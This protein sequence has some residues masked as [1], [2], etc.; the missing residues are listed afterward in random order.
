MMKLLPSTNMVCYSKHIHNISFP[1]FSVPYLLMPKS[2]TF[3]LPPFLPSS[4]PPSLISS[5]HHICKTHKQL[6]FIAFQ[7]FFL[8][9]II[10][11][12][13]SIPHSLQQYNTE[14]EE[15]KTKKN[16][17]FSVRNPNNLQQKP[18]PNRIYQLI[19]S[20]IVAMFIICTAT[21]SEPMT[22]ISGF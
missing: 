12:V 20:I 1:D 15:N 7:P 13:S 4:L 17:C 10:I 21:P 14:D 2:H 6:C 8:F 19:S 3:Y 5:F 9:I 22:Y 11:F 18:R 16:R